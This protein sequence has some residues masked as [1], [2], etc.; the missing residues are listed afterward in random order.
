MTSKLTFAGSF[1]GR[2]LKRLFPKSDVAR[3]GLMW[4]IGMPSGVAGFFITKSAL[5]K[6]RYKK[7]KSRQRIRDAL[8]A[9]EEKNALEEAQ[10]AAAKAAAAH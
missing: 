5:E 6:Q 2:F 4:F 3:T 8:K 1:V 7:M 9:N 10:A